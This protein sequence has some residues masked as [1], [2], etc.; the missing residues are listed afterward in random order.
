MG[1][2]RN[3]DIVLTNPDIF[4]LI[5][6]QFYLRPGDA[7]DKIVGPMVQKF[8]QFTFDEFHIFGTPQVVSVLNAMLFIHEVAGKVR[9]HKFLFLSATPHD[10]MLEYLERSG[11]QV[12]DIAGQYA[13]CDGSIDTAKWRRIL[14][15]SIIHF[16]VSRV[17]EWVDTHL[18]D[19]L[20]PFFLERTPHA[21]GAV[22]VNSV[23]AAHRLLDRLRPAFARHGLTVEPNTGLTSRQRRDV[24]Y[25][26]DLLVG[27]ST[28]DVGVDFQINFLL[29]E[30]RDAGSFLQR[31]GR[32]GRHDCYERDGQRY[33]FEDFVAYASVPQWVA[34]RLFIGR[35]GEEPLL[36]DGA[37]VDREELNRAVAEAYPLTA[38]FR[39]Y[40]HSW[41]KFQSVYVIRGLSSPT[42]REQHSRE[43]C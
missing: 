10:L 35:D 1:V 3:S 26:A 16:D 14:H 24:S 19:T 15:D 22:I 8:R 18:E 34:E 32:L 29:F 37:D 27:T 21:K 43:R 39:N 41:G 2:L 12:R 38:E 11:L 5:M 13:H 17:E 20:L 40:V 33:P 42:I 28:V 9:P 23:A 36:Q 7:P 6:E 25:E 30:S 4:H 31:L